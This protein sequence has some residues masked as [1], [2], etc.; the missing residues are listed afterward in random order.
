MLPGPLGRVHIFRG[1]WIVF[2]GYLTQIAS[3][4]ASGWVFGVLIL[5]M[6]HDLGWSR[7]TIVGVLTLEKLVG[8]ACSV[9]LGPRLDRYG[10]RAVMAGSAALGGALLL[11]ISQVQAPWQSYVLWAFM[12]LVSPGL[13]LLGPVVA[14]SNWFVRKRA[15]AI[16]FSTLSAATSALLLAPAMAAVADAM[17]WRTAWLLTGLLMWATIPF[18]W[19]AIRRRPEDVGLVPDGSPPPAGTEDATERRVVAE[20]E[21]DEF[22]TVPMALRSRSFWLLSLGFMLTTLPA[23][24]IYIHM[25]SFVQS[26]GFSVEA[27]AGAVSVYGLGVLAGRFI[28]GFAVAKAGLHRTL[29][30]YAFLY[31]LSIFLFT[32]PHTLFAI[33]ATTVFLG[34][35]IAGA[36][37]LRAQA[38]P[39]YF[40]RRIVGTLLGYATVISTITSASA[41]L[42]VAVAYDRTGSFV[43]TFLVWGACCLL[44]GTG[45]FFSKPKRPAGSLQASVSAGV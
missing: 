44:A 27:G 41:P 1:W 33:Y 32:L 10:A 30:T 19:L 4:G 29:V 16:M 9:W 21:V 37:Q 23:G 7:S 12:G 14:I 2:T 35:A 13:M 6:Q 38:F 15:Q 31:G 8:G 42:I 26:R 40:G 25:S 36:Q 11:L 22:W 39:D 28:W 43:P 3:G 18:S 45:F 17:S 5:P 24:S 20:N 34:V